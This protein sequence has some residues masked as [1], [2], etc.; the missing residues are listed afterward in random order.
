[1]VDPIE[2]IKVR[3]KLLQKR[4]E[5]GEPDAL[6]RLR[7]LPEL[8]K[9]TPENLKEFAVAIQRKHCFAVVSRELGFAGY[10]HAQRVL[11]GDE[12]EN[13]FG[14]MLYPSR[15]GAL[16]HWY[17]NYQEARDLRAEINGYLLAY[18]RHFFIVDGYF[19]QT[20]GLDPTDPDWDAIGRD[21]VKP[22]DSEARRRLYGKLLSPAA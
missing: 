11:S 1:M 3:A 9:S 13:D 4:I 16:N 17:A 18:K 15:C 22:A 21:W 19:I 20:L 12:A 5:H 10:Q 6:E 14:T 7:I 8:R 2:E